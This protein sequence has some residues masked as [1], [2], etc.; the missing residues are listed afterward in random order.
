MDSEQDIQLH[1]LISPRLLRAWNVLHAPLFRKE[2][3][4]LA[5]IFGACI[6]QLS[7]ILHAT[8]A[9]L[10]TTCTVL[11][12]LL[13]ISL[14]GAILAIHICDGDVSKLLGA[15]AALAPETSAAAF[16][17]F[18]HLKQ[19]ASLADLMPNDATAATAATAAKAAKAAVTTAKTATL[20]RN[21]L[22]WRA[23]RKML[24]I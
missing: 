18:P 1:Q 11:G 20:P 19:L 7:P 16:S 2:H 14:A 17:L 22:N 10:H 4:V 5:I 15:V 13:L 9:A 3:L 8:L 23:L 24:P 12:A 6:H 21:L